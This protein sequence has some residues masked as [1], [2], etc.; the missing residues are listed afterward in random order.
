MIFAHLQ[1]TCGSAV[2]LTVGD[3]HVDHVVLVNLPLQD[4]SSGAHGVQHQLGGELPLLE[5][6]GRDGAD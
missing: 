3:L 1:Q 5:G 4:V 2:Q 6:G